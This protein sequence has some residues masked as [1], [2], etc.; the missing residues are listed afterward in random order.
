MKLYDKAIELD[1][2]NFLAYYYKS[3]D[4]NSLEKWE[5]AIYNLDKALDIQMIILLFYHSKLGVYII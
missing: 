1:Q 5:D 3:L 2:D 4:I